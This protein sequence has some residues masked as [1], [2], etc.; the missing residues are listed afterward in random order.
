MPSQ[1]SRTPTLTEDLAAIE[2]QLSDRQIRRHGDVSSLR[3]RRRLVGMALGILFACV[4]TLAWDGFNQKSCERTATIQ[5]LQAPVQVW[6]AGARSWSMAT[7]MTQVGRGDTVRTGP[8]ASALL[9]SA[10]GTIIKMAPGTVVSIETWGYSRQTGGRRR[11]LQLYTGRIW[12]NAPPAASADS[13][14]DIRTSSA[15]ITTQDAQ[16]SVLTQGSTSLSVETGA[17]LLTA[18]GVMQ[19]TKVSSGEAVV[20]NGSA[21]EAPTP[22]PMP[23]TEAQLW[24]AQLS[25]PGPA[26]LAP[27]ADGRRALVNFEEQWLVRPIAILSSA[28]HIKSLSGDDE[29]AAGDANGYTPG[30]YQ[31]AMAAARRLRSAMELSSGS[32][33]SYPASVGLTDLSGM[34]MGPEMKQ[35]VLESIAQ[36]QLV[37][38]QRLGGRYKMYIRARRP[39]DALIL[40]T[41]DSIVVVPDVQL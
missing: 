18:R 12:L 30:A 41:P 27:G 25:Q 1:R 37:A 23:S 5:I 11:A 17:A 15:R 21:E 2:R 40:I 13:Y 24:H 29:D 6:S 9:T 19:R 4:A 32:G 36:H 8:G 34:S 28:A 22:F 39:S 10:D 31:M 35:V 38:Y 14:F 3:K 33:E 26:G 7:N 20:A 16:I